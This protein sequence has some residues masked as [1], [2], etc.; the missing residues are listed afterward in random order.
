MINLREQAE[1]DLAFTLEGDFK[2]PVVLWGPDGLKQD[3]SANDI[4]SDLGGMIQYDSVRMN[5][6][7]GEQMV[8]NEPI[9]VL[10][11]TSLTRIPLP[12]EKWVVQ[13]PTT[14]SV[15]ATKE[16]FMISAARSPEGGGSVGFIRLYLQRVTDSNVDKFFKNSD[17]ISWKDVSEIGWL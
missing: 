7:S 15:T 4:T 1:K 14:P 9:V 12:G 16:N 8:V 2:L 13:I 6:E 17:D 3:K 11:R 10:R 5:P